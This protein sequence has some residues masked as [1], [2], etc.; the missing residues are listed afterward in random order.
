MPQH[1]RPIWKAVLVAP[2]VAPLAITAAMAWE[3]IA[4]SGFSGFRDVPIV[5]LFLFAFG[6][7]LSY[8]VMLT[9]ALPY[10]LWLRSRNW[11]TWVPVCAGSVAL[12]A[13]IWTVY[14]QMSLRPPALLQTLVVGA[15]IGLI[16]GV[17]FCWA[18]GCRLRPE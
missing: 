3:S 1:R 5:A 18:A 6:L 9:L 12:G 2:I 10:V 13:T 11:L 7:P 16:V 8:I 4:A 14:W 17:V 15:F